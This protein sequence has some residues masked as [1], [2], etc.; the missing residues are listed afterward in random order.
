MQFHCNKADT[1]LSYKWVNDKCIIWITW[2][3]NCLNTRPEQEV[4]EAVKQ[5]NILFE[6]KEFGKLAEYVGCKIDYNKDDG[7]MTLMQPILLQSYE[8]KFGL[9]GHG[10]TPHTPA[11]TGSVLEKEEGKK[12]LGW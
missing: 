11:I 3:D 4:R 10:L 12:K 1:C 5:M 2:A 7:W 9:N 8:D 6:C